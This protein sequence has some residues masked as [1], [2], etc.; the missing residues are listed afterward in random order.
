[1]VI[2][3]DASVRKKSKKEKKEA[4]TRDANV[5]ML[6]LRNGMVILKSRRY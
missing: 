5:F 4:L 1:M 6:N 3:I 2:I